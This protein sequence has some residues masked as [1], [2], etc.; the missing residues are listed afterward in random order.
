M[1]KRGGAGDAT[2][3]RPTVMF[4]VPLILDRIYKVMREMIVMMIVIVIM[5]MLQ[6]VTEQ[7][8]RKSGLLQDIVNLCIRYRLDCINRGEVM[9]MTVMIMMMMMMM[10][11]G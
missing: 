10:M 6:G 3:L 11:C 9:K 7:I 4:C 5:M 8:R 2:L 1:I